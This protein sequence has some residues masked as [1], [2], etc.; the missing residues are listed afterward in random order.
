MSCG[1]NITI[2][3][4]ELI[5]NMDIQQFIRT[6]QFSGTITLM[7]TDDITKKSKRKAH[8]MGS[9]SIMSQV[10]EAKELLESMDISTDIWSVTSYTELQREALNAEREAL[11][12]TAE[13][14]PKSYIETILEK[15]T[16]VFVSVSDYMKSWGMG[17]SKWMPEAYH[18]LGTDGYGL[19]E[20]RTDLR[21]YF[22][23]SPKYIALAA[24]QLL[25]KE[26]EVTAKEVKDFIKAQNI[27]SAKINPAL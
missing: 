17:I 1:E 9:G 22:E 12:S 6:N 16:G 24:L 2:T 8:L 23:I 5:N 19:S 14:K 18:V 15:E 27:D 20:S 13:K 10:L 11:L 4:Y 21:D 3:E 25:R 7:Y 26:G